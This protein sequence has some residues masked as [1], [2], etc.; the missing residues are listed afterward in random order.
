MK[1]GI[2]CRVSTENQ[3]GKDKVSLDRQERLGVEYCERNGHDY[4]VYSE[5]V[6]GAT[7]TIDREEFFKL[8]SKLFTKEI[9]GIWFYDWD[10]MIRDFEIGFYF[11]KLVEDT[12]CKVFVLDRE[13]NI[14]DDADNLEYGIRVIFSDYERRKIRN[15]MIGGKVEKWRVGKGFSGQ[16]GIGYTRKDGYVVIDSKESKI[17]KDVF[18]Y[19]LRKDVKKYTQVLERIRKKYGDEDGKI[20][21]ISH[22]GRVRDILSDKK[23]LGVYTLTDQN[24]V[25]WDF[26]FGRIIDDD[27]FEQVQSKM[28]FVTSLRRGNAKYEYLL[29][30]KVRC[31]DCGGSM[32]VRGGG[33]PKD[34]G[35]RGKGYYKYYFCSRGSKA[36]YDFVHNSLDEKIKYTKDEIREN[37]CVS[38]DTAFNNIGVDKLETII[39]KG[40]KFILTKSD[41]IKSEYKSRYSKNLG[42]K[43]D[44]KGRLVVYKGKVRSLERDKEK[45]FN[46]YVAGK[47]DV[48]DYNNWK[49]T[50]YETKKRE[51][52]KIIK[53]LENEI[54]NFEDDGKFDDF[55]DV[56]LKDL[57]NRF[58]NKRFSHRR[59]LISQYIDYIDVR[60]KSANSKQYSVYIKLLFEDKIL[61]DNELI[62]DEDNI[63]LFFIKNSKYESL[64]FDKRQFFDFGLDINVFVLNNNENV[65]LEKCIFDF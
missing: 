26:N 60:R 54:E 38:V 21:G 61:K 48:A 64:G 36:K 56:M 1:V 37:V 10:R 63:N 6:S 34:K 28:N 45:V 58:R 12:K 15:R 46:D 5:V 39:W 40:L 65:V 14:F 33:T 29:K 55:V 16:V 9:N 3:R 22:T 27:V 43:E 2:Y 50:H 11:K 62:V 47:L 53:D 18:K 23:Y 8:E 25:E 4:E 35:G 13:Y 24:G 17:V 42:L 32:V 59:R 44:N 57:D 7:K 31:S 30:G 49:K 41:Y 52:N 20:K 19:F 51:I